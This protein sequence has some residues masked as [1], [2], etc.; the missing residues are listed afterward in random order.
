MDRGIDRLDTPRGQESGP[1]EPR[2]LG[3][4]IGGSHLKA[5]VM[6]ASGDMI[7]ERRQTE[8]PSPATPAAVCDALAHLVGGLPQFDRISVGFP[9]AVRSGHV[10]TAPN[11]GTE[12][13]HQ[14]PL[15]DHLRALLGAPVRLL[16]DA[17]VAGLGVIEGRG[18]ECMITLGTGMGFAVFQNGVVG[19]HL[20]L[21]HIPVRHGMTYDEYVGEAARKRVGRKHWSKR[22]QRVIGY[23]NVLVMYDRLYIGGGNARRLRFDPREGVQIVPNQAGI[24]GGV[25]LWDPAMD[26]MFDPA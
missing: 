15:S 25:R 20:E 24:T 3:I 18:V 7:G 9:G 23:L 1:T 12:P 22:V 4:D 17:E 13:W 14:F 11:L 6:D 5:G 19:P 16:N 8:T 10:L 26:R 2:T 21:S